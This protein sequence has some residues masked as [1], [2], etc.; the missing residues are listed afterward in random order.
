MILAI[1]LIAGFFLPYFAASAFSTSGISGFDFIKTPGGKADKY[2]LLLSPLAGLLLLIGAASA[3]PILSRGVLVLLAV[4]GV[5]YLPIR[6]LID[7]ADFGLLIKMLGLGYWLSL[8]AA[9]LLAF[10]NPKN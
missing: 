5:L 2:I 6:S 9:L 8:V 1:V 10:A 4:I 3:K 7:G